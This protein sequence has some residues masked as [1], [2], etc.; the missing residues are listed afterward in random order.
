[1]NRFRRFFAA[2]FWDTFDAHHP[3]IPPP[4]RLAELPRGPPY[5]SW[6]KNGSRHFFPR[7]VLLRLGQS[8][9]AAAHSFRQRFDKSTW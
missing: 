4:P 3:T 1:V 6:L 5:A 7:A 9:A 2:H 8:A